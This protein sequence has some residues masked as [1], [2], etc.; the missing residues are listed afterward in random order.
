MRVLP[1]KPA[2]SFASGEWVQEYGKAL[3]NGK[4]YEYYV[5]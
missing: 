1:P 5:F 3:S 4:E 2:N